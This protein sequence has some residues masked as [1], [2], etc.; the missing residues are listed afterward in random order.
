MA[1]LTFPSAPANGDLYPVSPVL[2]Q[3]QYEW[4]STAQTWRLVGVSVG[5][6]PGTYG[7][8]TRVPQ[9]TVDVQGRIT[10]ITDY[11][12]T[13][14]VE[15]VSTPASSTAAGSL[16]QIAFGTGYFYFYDGTRWLRTAGS[17]F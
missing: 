14:N 6:I 15:Y 12:L 4:D 17:T 5:I 10:A 2:G 16:G 9:V 3:N 13:A 8:A 1:L 11:P 7:G